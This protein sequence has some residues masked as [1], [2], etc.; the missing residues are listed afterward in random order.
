M[1][2]LKL[3]LL[4]SL[5]TV[6]VFCFTACANKYEKDEFEDVEWEMSDEPQENEDQFEDNTDVYSGRVNTFSID[7]IPI[8]EA[9]IGQV[10]KVMQ[11]H[12]LDD[13]KTITTEEW[14]MFDQNKKHQV[15]EVF[16]SILLDLEFPVN[17]KEETW[18]E[19][20]DR[21][22]DFYQER[23]IWF[24]AFESLGLTGGDKLSALHS[25]A[26]GIEDE[27]YE[28]LHP[29]ILAVA[30]SVTIEYHRGEYMLCLGGEHEIIHLTK[31][32]S[33]QESCFELDGFIV[34]IPKEDMFE[35]EHIDYTIAGEDGKMT[36]AEV[37]DA[38][39][40][41]VF[42]AMG[43]IG[44]DGSMVHKKIQISAND[45]FNAPSLYILS[46]TDQKEIKIALM[47][48]S[49]SSEKYVWN[50]QLLT[51]SERTC[52]SKDGYFCYINKDGELSQIK[53]GK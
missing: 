46:E 25:Y 37:G 44:E 17:T 21:L 35:T 40:L 5:L 9:Y 19:E 27:K 51:T 42:K 43:A 39:L 34:A 6:C 8:T 31:E 36:L 41:S 16:L 15:Y 52:F 20:M 30:D 24:Y 45:S 10:Y 14:M 18:M 29:E 7:D 32:E 50:N 11:L 38:E 47:K 12:S 4:F 1:K 23:M 2:L 22:A 3:F 28:P 13:Y 49:Q 48:Y 33:T 26:Q 53:E